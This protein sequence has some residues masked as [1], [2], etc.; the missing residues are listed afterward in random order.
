MEY[1]RFGKTGL[2]TPV[3]SC[4]GM[5]YQQSWKGSDEI[6][7]ESQKNVE[8][9]VAKA[10]ELGI[11]HFETARGYGTSE[12]QLGRILPKLPRD[13]LIVQTKIGPMPDLEKF[14]AAFE[15]FTAYCGKYQV[16][17]EAGAVTHHL[18]GSW[19]P[20]W[21]NTDQV[22]KYHFDGNRLQL[23]TEPRPSRRASWTLSLVWEREG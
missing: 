22:R 12:E 9:C 4:G 14:K 17:E 6:T 18:D 15:K 23:D 2:K 10:L 7:E 11:T 21:E 19:F 5:R 16:D 1:R 20:N 3:F 13:D 8:A